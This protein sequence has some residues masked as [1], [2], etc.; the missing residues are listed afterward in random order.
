MS[1]KALSMVIHHSKASPTARHVLTIIAWYDTESGAWPSQ[2][3]IAEKTG[4]TTRTVKRAIAEL[5]DIGEI[6]V[7]ANQGGSNGGR[8]SNLYV[9]LLDCPDG[10]DGSFAHRPNRGHLR[11]LRGHLRQTSGTSTTDFGDTVSPNIYILK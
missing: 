2:E 3:T 4:L 9:F 8:R 10:C 11:P 6:D 5:L 7:I 1:S